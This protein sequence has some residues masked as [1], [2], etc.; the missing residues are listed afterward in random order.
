VYCNV[1]DA[2]VGVSLWQGHATKFA[3]NG[4]AISPITTGF[5]GGQMEGGTFGAAVDTKDNAW[6]TSYGRKSIERKSHS[7]TKSNDINK[8]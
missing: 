3:P 8:L 5:T 4:R 6:L 1:C 7:L 2:S